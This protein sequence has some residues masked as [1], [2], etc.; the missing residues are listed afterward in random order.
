MRYLMVV[1][2]VLGMFGVGGVAHAEPLK[3]SDAGFRAAAIARQNAVVEPHKRVF[4][5]HLAKVSE[6]QARVD[7]AS[8]N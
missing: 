8:G 5:L 3:M 2:M 6:R 4:W 7:K 1:G